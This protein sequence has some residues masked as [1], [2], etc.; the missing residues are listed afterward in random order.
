MAK[1]VTL[2]ERRIAYD[3]AFSRGEDAR[4]SEL[5][6][7]IERELT[8]LHARYDDGSEIL[9]STYHEGAESILTLYVRAAARRRTK[10][11]SPF[12]PRCSAPARLSTTM[13]DPT[14]R[15][16]GLPLAISPKR[17]R[18]GFVYADPVPIRKRPGHEVFRALYW[19][20]NRGASPKRVG[21]K[22]DLVVL[23]LR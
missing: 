14:D 7:S 10:S 18:P 17:W 2:D 16:V 13:A 8:P 12:G 9:G 5:L 23:D 6:A 1:P 15:E 3:I 19:A 21:A 4:A 22:E 11:S 20:R